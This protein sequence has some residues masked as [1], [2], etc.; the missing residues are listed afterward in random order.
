MTLSLSHFLS[1]PLRSTIMEFL[2]VVAVYAVNATDDGR[3]PPIVLFSQRF[4][5]PSIHQIIIKNEPDIRFDGH[6]QLTVDGF[7]LEVP[8]PSAGSSP[9]SS[10]TSSTSTTTSNATSPSTSAS[11]SSSP[12]VGS[13]VGGVFGALAFLAIIGLAFCFRIRRRP[14]R[15]NDHLA[16]SGRPYPSFVQNFSPGIST[17][18]PAIISPTADTV[19]TWGSSAAT[20]TARPSSRQARQGHH[21]LGAGHAEPQSVSSF[22][23]ATSSSRVGGW[24]SN[25]PSS[26]SVGFR[27]ERDAGPAPVMEEEAEDRVLPPGYGDVFA[28]NRRVSTVA[29]S[30]QHGGAEVG[31]GSRR[32]TV[33]SA[34]GG[35]SPV[36]RK[37]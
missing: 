36:R 28:P 6:S 5:T 37:M 4:N 29:G 1:L 12:P 34:S 3:N 9:S 25:F 21:A 18:A 7:V 15:E 22:S 14:A 20:G 23:D 2:A 17:A 19:F 32:S 16:E 13:I 10:S 24:G 27:R 33:S 35:L 11:A 31:A 8:D 30:Q 26:P